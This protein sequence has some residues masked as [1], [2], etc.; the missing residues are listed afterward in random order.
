MNI[1]G[2]ILIVDDDDDDHV[3]LQEIFE[4]LGV[5]KQAIFFHTG[6][7]LLEYMKTSAV[8]PFIILCDIN[9]PPIDGLEL[10]ELI[11]KDSRLKRMSIPYVFFSTAAAPTQV[12]RAYDLMVQGF[13]LKAKTFEETQKRIKLILDYWSECRVPSD[14]DYA[15]A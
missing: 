10:R 15:L 12:K 8:Q 7:E 2:P 1:T 5:G 11:C 6:Y 14:E 9:M 4:I 3:L 13:F